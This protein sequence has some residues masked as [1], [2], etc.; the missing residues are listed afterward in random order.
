MLETAQA[1]VLCTLPATGIGRQ[2][3]CYCS[4]SRVDSLSTYID[5][6]WTTPFLM[7]KQP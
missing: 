6:A 5:G 3:W 7:I 1:H 4:V 2:A